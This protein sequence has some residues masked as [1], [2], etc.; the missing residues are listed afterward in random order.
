MTNEFQ[1]FQRKTF[2]VRAARVSPLNIEELAKECGGKLMHDGEKDGNLSRDYIKVRVQYPLNDDQTKARV[3]DWLVKQGRNWKVYKD[4]AFRNTFEYPDGTQVAAEPPK[5]QESPSPAVMP[6]KLAEGTTGPSHGQEILSADEIAR[7]EHI[8]QGGTPEMVI[9]SETVEV[10][11][12]NPEPVQ[13]EAVATETPVEAS[14]EESVPEEAQAAE[15]VTDGTPG[16]QTLEALADESPIL[17]AE[18]SPEG[19]SGEKQSI[20]LDELN[21][22]PGDP[23]SA[24]EI[25]SD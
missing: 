13:E 8:S 6:K 3:G 24:Q 5:K 14:P 4:K 21:D 11:V 16:P 1:G 17:P 20:T 9:T 7:L 15:V 10:P 12:V 25:M 18:N 23:R 19:E 2:S 22:M